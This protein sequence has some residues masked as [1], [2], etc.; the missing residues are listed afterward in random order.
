MVVLTTKKDYYKI[1]SIEKLDNLYYQDINIK[2]LENEEV[3][4]SEIKKILK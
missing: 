1:R 2:F 4:N 3:F